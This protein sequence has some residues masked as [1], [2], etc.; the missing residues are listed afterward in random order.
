MKG[1]YAM[2]RS[3][4]RCSENVIAKH[5]FIEQL[6]RY[7]L[8]KQLRAPCAHA[9]ESKDIYYFLVNT[10]FEVLLATLQM[11]TV[12]ICISF[13]SCSSSFSCLVLQQSRFYI[14]RPPHRANKK[15][16]HQHYL[17]KQQLIEKKNMAAPMTGCS[18]LSNV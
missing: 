5:I 3:Y 10:K 4:V 7:I 11:L 9:S 13:T 12:V 16:Q 17:Q 18:V 8:Q 1:R 14:R 6:I 15:Q 2:L